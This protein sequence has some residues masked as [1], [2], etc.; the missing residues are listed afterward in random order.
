[1]NDCHKFVAG[2]RSW[3]ICKGLE[4][5]W[6]LTDVNKFR[7]K[8]EIFELLEHTHVTEGTPDR[9][10]KVQVLAQPQEHVPNIGT[11]V[12][13]THQITKPHTVLNNT[14]GCC[15]GNKAKVPPIAPLVPQ[16]IPTDGPG[17]KLIDLFKSVG[18]ETC[19]ACYML[20]QKMDVWGIVG[21]ELHLNEILADILPRALAWEQANLGWWK[22]LMPESVTKLGIKTIVQKAIEQSKQVLK[23]VDKKTTSRVIGATLSK[24]K[25]FTITYPPLC[26]EKFVVARLKKHFLY[27]V[28]PLGGEH[29]WCLRKNISQVC[30]GLSQFNGKKIVA[31]STPGNGEVR[32][33]LT[34]EEVQ[35]LFE[36]EGYKDIEYIEVKNNKKLREVVSFVPLMSKVQSLN[37]DEVVF[38]GHCKGVTHQSTTSICHPW[39]DAMYETVYN[40]WEQAQILLETHGIV[41]SFKKYGMFKTLRNHRWHY[42]GTFY[43]FRSASVFVRNWSY[44]DQFFYGTES[45]P[46]MLFRPEE[47]ACLFWDNCKDMYKEKLE[48]IQQQLQLWRV[49]N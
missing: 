44:I 4:P 26:T 36:S 7:I 1:M 31:I 38:Y 12:P 18:F 20:A 11:I 34:T 22:K 9:P 19:D 10:E 28:L 43:W 16:F 25:D 42:S 35:Q 49:S 33:F 3:N 17:S 14:K 40:N 8:H 48:N 13:V 15:G 46:G 5:G 45:W 24:P 27:H 39:A 32:K 47:G 30:Q 37:P 6:S 41:G 2:S 29:E 21:C 23:K